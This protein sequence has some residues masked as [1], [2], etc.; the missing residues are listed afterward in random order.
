MQASDK[1]TRMASIV[2]P[3][4]FGRQV[5]V[6]LTT[7]KTLTGELAEVSPSYIVLNTK[8]GEKQIMVHAII[9][10][11]PAEQQADA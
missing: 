9:A 10:I 3:A 1:E 4:W 2:K 5:T 6:M 7:E 8:S 11:W